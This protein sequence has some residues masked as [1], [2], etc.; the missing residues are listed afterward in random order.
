MHWLTSVTNEDTNTESGC[1]ILEGNSSYAMH[2]SGF[3]QSLGE[4]G[5]FDILDFSV[6]ELHN[7]N[8]S[9]GWFSTEQRR[10]PAKIRDAS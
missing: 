6:L 5:A 9:I 4:A 10:E 2:T 7:T 1:W 8:V 3:R